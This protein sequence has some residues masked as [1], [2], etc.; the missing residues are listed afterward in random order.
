MDGVSVS[1]YKANQVVPVE[2]SSCVFI[3]MLLVADN[4][5]SPEVMPSLRHTTLLV[6][7]NKGPGYLCLPSPRTPVWGM[8]QG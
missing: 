3:E 7:G 8:G 2:L 6:Y 1:L 5:V 4:S